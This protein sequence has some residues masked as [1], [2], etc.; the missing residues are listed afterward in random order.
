MIKD[1]NLKFQNDLH[2]KENILNKRIVELSDNKKYIEAAILYSSIYEALLVR[3]LELC[4]EIIERKVGKSIQYK[5]RKATY[6]INDK[7][8]TLGVLINLTERYFDNKELFKKL[9]KFNNEVRRKIIHR[10]FDPNI[11]VND[12]NNDLGKK[13]SDHHKLLIM[14][15]DQEIELLKEL[16]VILKGSVISQ[17][18]PSP[19]SLMRGN[20]K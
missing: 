14:L 8:F 4:E 19:P 5:A 9:R 6:F 16:K 13:W 3:M 18:L 7:N 11:E 15:F 2:N 1:E 17:V 10:L 12:L 20:S